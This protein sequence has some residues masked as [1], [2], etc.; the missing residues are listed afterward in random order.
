MDHADGTPIPPTQ[1][2]LYLQAVADIRLDNSRMVHVAPD[3]TGTTDGSFP[4][5]LD[6]TIH[7]ITAHNPCGRTVSP[8]D[9][10]RAH[11]ALLDEIRSRALT[12]WPATGRDVYSA[13]TEPSAAI[14]GLNDAEARELGRQFRQ[15]AVFAWSPDTWRLLSCYSNQTA[16]RGWRATTSA[17]TVLE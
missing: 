9:N 17:V 14:V 1:W 13:H 8:Q 7:V 4:D 10:D 3:P 16:A 15:D 12:W 11:A 5:R 2:A 6:R